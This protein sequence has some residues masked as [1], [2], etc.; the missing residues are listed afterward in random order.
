MIKKML[1]NNNFLYKM[2]IY[3]IKMIKNLNQI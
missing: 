3:N 2:N 1:I